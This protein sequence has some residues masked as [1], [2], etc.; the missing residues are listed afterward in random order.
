MSSNR[1]GISRFFGKQEVSDTQFLI[2]IKELLPFIK[3][4]YFDSSES[5][6]ID[7]IEKMDSSFFQFGINNNKEF[8][9]QTSNSPEI[10]EANVNQY[11]KSN[12]TKDFKESFLSLIKNDKLQNA[13]KS[14]YKKYKTFKI[15]SE[16]FPVLTHRGDS[17]GY[18]I[19]NATKY[20]KSKFGSDGALVLF[21]VW[22]KDE[23]NTWV[24][25]P[26]KISAEII[27]KITNAS[28]NKWKIYNNENLKIPFI[29]DFKE[30]KALLPSYL[31]TEQDIDNAIKKLESKNKSFHFK[32]KKDL[33]PIKMELQKQLDFLAN[34]QSSIFS[35]EN[36]QNPIE[37][38]ILRIKDDSGKTI[39]IKGTSETFQVQKEKIWKI[40]NKISSLEKVLSQQMLN[41]IFNVFI[42]DKELNALISNAVDNFTPTKNNSQEIE[43]EFLN[44]L[45]EKIT[46]KPITSLSL[47]NLSNFIRKI[48]DD[49]EVI[50]NELQNEDFD[51]DTIR[52]SYDSI[53]SFDEKI[54][55][56][57]N[58]LISN[59]S[60]PEKIIKIFKELFNRNLEKRAGKFLHYSAPFNETGFSK[61]YRN[62]TPVII[63]VGRAQ[64]WHIGHHQMIEL[65]KSKFNE[66]GAKVVLIILVK[67][68]KTSSDID[69]NPLSEKD[70]YE[71]LHSLYGEDSEVLIAQNTIL[72]ANIM[73]ILNEVINN[74]CYIVGFLAG[75]DRIEEYK[76]MFIRFNAGLWLKDHDYLPLKV[77][78]DGSQDIEFILTPRVM[79][80]TEARN[81]VKTLTFENWIKKVLPLQL[82]TTTIKVYKK[83]Y[84]KIKSLKENTILYERIYHIFYS[85][86]LLLE[87]EPLN[88]K[89][90]PLNKKEI[91]DVDEDEKANN[92]NKEENQDEKIEDVGDDTV[93][94]LKSTK[95]LDDIEEID[96][97]QTQRDDKEIKP[98]DTDVYELSQ[99]NKQIIKKE[100]GESVDF[101]TVDVNGK[102]MVKLDGE[103]VNVEVGKEGKL[104][105][106]STPEQGSDLKD[107]DTKPKSDE[108]VIKDIK[109]YLPEFLSIKDPEFYK[110]ILKN[111]FGFLWKSFIWMAKAHNSKGGSHLETIGNT[112]AEFYKDINEKIKNKKIKAAEAQQLL[113][114]FKGKFV[115]KFKEYDKLKKKTEELFKEK[116]N[117]FE[118][119]LENRRVN[120]YINL[121]D[122]EKKKS[123]NASQA[124][125]LLKSLEIMYKEYENS[126]SNEIK[127]KSR[128]IKEIYTFFFKMPPEKRNNTLNE[129]EV[130][131]QFKKNGL[132]PEEFSQFLKNR[133]PPNIKK[134]R[135]EDEDRLEELSDDAEELR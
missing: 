125:S 65:A 7:I 105:P 37:G 81:L 22:V 42:S 39:E 26:H 45:I 56:M 55:N 78:N 52:K 96:N 95:K 116:K 60:E 88:K 18:I 27:E 21:K 13:L 8:F 106:L 74:K 79:S 75:E 1:E 51:P 84:E 57:K 126:K 33:I 118:K 64:P 35:K 40:R 6:K 32:L 80:G 85:N 20:D 135:D 97:D 102:K 30:I 4:G 122:S 76:K 112:V 53:K 100:D 68:S 127:E 58:V 108:E 132:K 110:K 70:Q 133:S 111:T 23:N 66:I 19:F 89:N 103:I 115:N 9:V 5:D 104:Q 38:V 11:F 128:K 49:I 69:K 24:R 54:K 114:K 86:H 59:L 36:D 31:Q 134:N 99:D 121:K 48:E 87:R 83:M 46:K 28:N 90:N 41:E 15:D 62:L 12:V 92:L 3:K 123:N 129:K 73:N 98:L 44:Y 82:S 109:T 14:V 72:S 117:D 25:P 71:M 91:Q 131:N 93:E 113:L 77:K 120:I 63:W 119:I 61:Y 94:E 2:I 47:E 101:E 29:I 16:L 107:T 67:G 43:N 17:S 124:E 10:T 50:K 34:N 130:V